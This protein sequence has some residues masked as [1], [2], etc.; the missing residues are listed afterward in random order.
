[1]YFLHDPPESII[2]P[3]YTVWQLGHQVVAE[4][5][6]S[7]AAACRGRATRTQST[8]RRFATRSHTVVANPA[9]TEAGKSPPEFASGIPMAQPAETHVRC[10]SLP[11]ERTEPLLQTSVSERNAKKRRFGC[12]TCRLVAFVTAYGNLVVCSVLTHVEVASTFSE[13]HAYSSQGCY[14]LLKY[15]LPTGR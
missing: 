1:M 12:A 3:A 4:S 9:G 7:T 8:C 10:T 13:R 2:M 6:S 14:P 5:F 11:H 15:L